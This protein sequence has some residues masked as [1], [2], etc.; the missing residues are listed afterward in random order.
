MM[1]LFSNADMIALVWFLAAWIGYSFIIEMTPYGKRG[2][3]GLMHRYRSLWMERMLARDARMMDG[4]VIASLQN[5]TAFFAST[6]LIA[7]GGAVTLFHSTEDMLTVIATLPFGKP[8]THV[9]WEVKV[10]GLMIVFVYAFFKFAWSYRLYNYVAI[11]VGAAPPSS[12]RDEP[13][14]KAYAQTAAAVITDAGRHFNRGQ[15]AFFFALGYLGW[16]LGPLPLI[17]T[18]ASIVV[19]M[20]RRQFVSESRRAVHDT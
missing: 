12:E 11:M 17:V 5:G 16:F 9:E 20:W 18:T 3:N 2:L 4:Q 10:V 19:V 7:L 13:E 6:S 14:A 15:R 1:P 8:V